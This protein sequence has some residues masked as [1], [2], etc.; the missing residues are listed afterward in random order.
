[1]NE[2]SIIYE[3]YT[4]KINRLLNQ[5]PADTQRQDNVVMTSLQRPYNVVSTSCA[6]IKVI[7]RN[8]MNGDKHFLTEIY[9]KKEEENLKTNHK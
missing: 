5:Y 9:L 2:R 7:F 8:W 3:L 4:P 1:M 6:G